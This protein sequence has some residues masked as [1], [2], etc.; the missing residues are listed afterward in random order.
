MLGKVFLKGGGRK[1]KVV[2][3]H[4]S[5]KTFSRIVA[6]VV[7][8]GPTFR[9]SINFLKRLTHSPTLSL[10]H[11]QTHTPRSKLLSKFCWHKFWFCLKNESSFETGLSLIH[12]SITSS[13]GPRWLVGSCLYI[14]RAALPKQ[15]CSYPHNIIKVGR[16]C[17]SVGRVV[18]RS[19]VRTQ[20]STIIYIEHLLPVNCIERTKIN[21]N[22]PG[23]KNIFKVNQIHQL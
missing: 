11:T 10:T 14:A 6:V 5:V 23:I 1:I 9:W 21:K 13:Q 16:G 12:F 20:S 17:G 8:V 22:R 4:T 19:T 18:Q 2:S 7:A 3:R 15:H